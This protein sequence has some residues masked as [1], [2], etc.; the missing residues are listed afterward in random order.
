MNEKK[1]ILKISKKELEQL[2][3]A[4]DLLLSP[5]FETRYLGYKMFVS[6]SL[7]KKG[8][9]KSLV[10]FLS[11]DDSLF[12]AI[13][14]LKWDIL[15]DRSTIAKSQ[16]Y[17]IYDKYINNL[18]NLCRLSPVK[19]LIPEEKELF[20][21]IYENLNTSNN[22]ELIKNSKKQLLESKTIQ[23]NRDKFFKYEQSL[24]SLNSISR[25]LDYNMSCYNVPYYIKRVLYF[26]NC[27]IYDD[28]K[29]Y[30][31]IL[32]NIIIEE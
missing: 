31:K 4:K 10:P 15:K 11:P 28:T 13:M 20:K 14:I 22:K 27:L 24:L 25:Y 3:K 9:P 21:E 16:V 26:L 32:I 17:Y 7:Y 29:F 5:D 12:D 8:K 30:E 23:D 2:E 1:E 6:T 19:I 18:N